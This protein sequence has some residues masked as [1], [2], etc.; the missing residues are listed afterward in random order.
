MDEK[1]IAGVEAAIFASKGISLKKLCRV[2]KMSEDEMKEVLDI[3]TK[4]Y[5]QEKHGIELKEVEGRYRFYTKKRYGEIVYKAAGKSFS[6]LSTSQLEVVVIILLHG[7]LSRKE[8]EKLRGKDSSN[9]LRSLV[10]MRVLRRKRKGRR[11]VYTF[12]RSFK[13]SAIYE[14]VLN[15]LRSDENV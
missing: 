4:E 14:E 3:I 6:K 10:E 1:L 2:F 13:E 8:I 11:V 5:E 15:M 7:E 9:I 12:T